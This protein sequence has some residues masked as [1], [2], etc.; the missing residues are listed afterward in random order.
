MERKRDM[1]KHVTFVAALQIGFGVIGIMG[2]FI[3]FF[4][5]NFAESFIKDVEIAVIILDM[6]KIFLPILVIV[7]SVLR[8]TG[9]LGLLGYKTWSRILVIVISALDCLSVPIGT[10]RGVYSIWALLQEDTVE[11]FEKDKGVTY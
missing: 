3:L 9:G 7:I 10:A 5:L 4:L 1:R 11:L 8:L 2:A 6:A